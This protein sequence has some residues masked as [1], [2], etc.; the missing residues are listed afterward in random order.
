MIDSM[1][2]P[3]SSPNAKYILVGLLLIAGALAVVFGTCR[4]TQEEEPKVEEQASAPNN[5]ERSTSLGSNTLNLAEV[6]EKA[7]AP[8]PAAPK[9]RARR[10]S[11]EWDCEGEL[12]ASAA[13]GVINAN[14]SAVRSCYER[15]LKNDNYLQGSVN[16]KLKISP[17][18]SVEAVH[19]SGTLRD[20][21]VYSCIRKQAQA[22]NFPAP[23][24]GC[25]VISAPFNF[26]PA[27]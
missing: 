22:W 27:G 4:D 14:R 23:Q 6:E 21:T 5:I 10:A 16:V 20:R 9:R 1:P 3:S 12:A 15:R 19:L 18:G 8:E 11:T 24:A 7:P 26:T 25:A 13:L 2:P 17:T